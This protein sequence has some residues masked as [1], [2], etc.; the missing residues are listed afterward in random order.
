M[1]KDCAVAGCTAMTSGYSTHCERHKRAQRRHGHPDQDGVTVHQLHPFRDRV[2]ARKDKNPANPAWEILQSRWGAVAANAETH[3]NG[4]AGG[5]AGSVYVIQAA[6]HIR[7]LAATV[8]DAV[9]TE[10]ALAM[11]IMR[12]VQPHRFRSDRAFDFQLA[13]RVR[14]LSDVNAGT[15]F[16]H[17]TG[18]TKRVYRDVLPGTLVALAEPLKAAFGVAGVYLAE[19]DRRDEAQQSVKR[20]ELIS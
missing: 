3:L 6:H 14:A 9:V 10:T 8:P 12:E 13:R 18:K 2:A 16:D 5:R 17:H 1:S 15:Y 11:F 7:R 20:M 19:L 4:H